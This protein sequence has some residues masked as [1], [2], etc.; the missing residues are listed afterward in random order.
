MGRRENAIRRIKQA[1]V[2]NPQLPFVH[3]NIGLARKA[4][5]Q[6]DESAR[7]FQMAIDIKPNYAGAYSNLGLVLEAQ[8][9]VVPAFEAY[10]QA[11]KL[12]PDLAEAHSNIG[13]LLLEIGQV[14]TAVK[15]YQQACKLASESSAIHSSALHAFLHA[16]DFSIHTLSHKHIQWGQQF[17]A[18]AKHFHTGSEC[19]LHNRST[20]HVGYVSPDFR[21][22]AWSY[23]LEPILLNHDKQKVKV[24]CYS[25]VMREDKK[26]EF[27]KSISDQWR[28][29][30]GLSDEQAAQMI[31]N[32]EIDI[33]VNLAGHTSRN[34]LSLFALK[35]ARIQ[36]ILGHYQCTTG[37]SAID[38]R[39]T[40]RW[41]DPP[42]SKGLYCETLS[43]LAYGSLCYSPPSDVPETHLSPAEKKGCLTFGSLNRLS[44]INRNVVSIWARL[45]LSLPDARLI[46]KDKWLSD[47]YVKK[48]VYD[49][50]HSYGI[51][52]QRLMLISSVETHKEHLDLYNQVDIALDPYPVNGQTT[53]CESLW[54]GV[55][56][57]TLVGNR[58]SQRFGYSLLS[59]LE[60]VDLIAHSEDEYILKAKDLALDIDKRQSLRCQLR[61][62]MEERICNASVFVRELEVMY[63]NMIDEI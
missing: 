2:I 3:N 16:T 9:K 53:S 35:P 54:M 28:D 61:S 29:I 14:N 25:N 22:H 32:D 30:S 34:R 47:A 26:T 43:Y 5:G 52:K 48:R 24:F 44:K 63:Q 12:T 19:G 4:L 46:L 31:A 23:F 39:I 27:F 7:S 6:L 55:P 49:V 38:Y 17:Q 51:T 11:L 15:L 40:D 60:L 36:A 33:L 57:V 13:R 20:I 56:V 10:K 59:R 8:G 58:C 21:Q 42:E 18:N 62:K 41:V 50:F 1:L 37:L 45:L